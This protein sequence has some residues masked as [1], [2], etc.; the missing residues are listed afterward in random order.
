MSVGIPSMSDMTLLSESIILESSPPEAIFARGLCG[1]PGFVAIMN[2]TRSSP[3]GEGSS[4]GVTEMA[5]RTFGISRNASD[6]ATRPSS[7]A[8][9]A[10]RTSPRA[11]PDSRNSASSA[12]SRRR[13]SASL[14]SPDSRS[15][16]FFSA[17]ARNSSISSTVEP[18][19]RLSLPIASRRDSTASIF[20]VGSPSSAALA[21]EY[22]SAAISSISYRQVSSRSAN[23]RYSG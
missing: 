10:L 17:S 22:T 20:A 16:S 11:A 7:D 8:A 4:S 1:S 3:H 12:D 18:Y 14:S 6:S 19:L 5:K 15:A 9:A 2:S 21:R 13:S 23:P